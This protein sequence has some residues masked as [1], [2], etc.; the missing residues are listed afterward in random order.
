MIL[1]DVLNSCDR[2]EL[3]KYMEV[4]DE[5][6]P[7]ESYEKLLENLDKLEPTDSDMTIRVREMQVKKDNTTFIDVFGTKPNDEDTYALEFMPWAQWLG[8][9]VNEEDLEKWGAK[10]FCGEVLF[11]MS[12]ISFDQ[13]EI[14]SVFDTIK[15]AVDEIKEKEE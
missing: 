6:N 7:I 2:A 4:I 12:F 1:K 9:E 14:L 15:D 11:E 3:L 8:S 5:M 10:V 13:N